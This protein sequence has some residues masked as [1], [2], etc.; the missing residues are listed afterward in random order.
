MSG[1]KFRNKHVVATYECDN[2]RD[3]T[4]PALINAMVETSGL[5]SH[6]LGNT[7]EQMT[8]QGL[9]WIII[10]YDINVNRMP[11]RREEII[12]ETEALSFN[13]FFTYRAFRAFDKEDNLL[14]EA[15][16]TFSVMDMATRK[17][18]QVDKKLVAP[19]QAEEIRTMVRA[20]KI[21]PV[22]PETA[23]SMPYRVRY[24]DIDGNMHVNNAK[25]FDWIINSVDVKILEAYKIKA[26]TIKYEKEV[27]FGSII[28]SHV[29]VE[30]MG[31][32]QL[33]TAHIIENGGGRACIANITWEHR[34]MDQVKKITDEKIEIDLGYEDT[35][36]EVYTV[37]NDEFKQLIPTLIDDDITHF[38]ISEKEFSKK[39]VNSLSIVNHGL[40]F[41]FFEDEK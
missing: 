2:M 25:Y 7:E 30:K 1:L 33:K 39:E 35:F 5:Q 8:E 29:S 40:G 28:E 13:R 24:L 38:N 34:I 14:V 10:Q 17:L 6:A 32:G 37:D 20:P 3:M 15:I 19:Y 21:Q 23:T 9:A 41:M 12:L 18:T 36:I 27:G 11:K 26:V 16:T 22:N 31:D 4:L